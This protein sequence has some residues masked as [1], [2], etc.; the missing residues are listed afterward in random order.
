MNLSCTKGIMQNTIE[1]FC[2]HNKLYRNEGREGVENLC[3]LLNAMGYNDPQYF[4]QFHQNGNFGDLICF[5]EDNSGCVEA[6]KEWI[7]EQNITEWKENL[8]AELPEVIKDNYDNG[9]CPD[10]GEEIPDDALSGEECSNCGHVWTSCFCD[11][12]GTKKKIFMQENG[13]C[14]EEVYGCSDCDS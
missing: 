3:R 9:E 14:L 6:I 5:L 1:K 8:E 7:A 4:G 2:D 11:H 10:C 13:S 12:C